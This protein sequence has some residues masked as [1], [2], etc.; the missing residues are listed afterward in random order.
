VVSTRVSPAERAPVGLPPFG[1][2]R[3]YFSNEL[4]NA[5][6]TLAGVVV[7]TRLVTPE[8]YG[9]YAV[10]I[11][12]ASV[13]MA[14]CG[15]WLQLSTLRLVAAQRR[16]SHRQTYVRGLLHLTLASTGALLAAAAA[17]LV[18]AGTPLVRALVVMGWLYATLNVLFLGTTIYFQATLQPARFARYRSAYSVLRVLFAALLAVLLAPSP[19]WLVAGSVLGLVVLLPPAIL[20]VLRAQARAPTAR[21]VAAARARVVRFGAP[22]IG[23]FAASQ[24]LN[25][26]DRFFLQGLLGSAEVGMYTVTYALVVG[27]T[28]T[29][30]QP[31]LAAVYPPMVSAWQQDGPAAAGHQLTGALRLFVLLAPLLLAGLTLYGDD[32]LAVLVPSAYQTPRLLVVVLA[33][34]LLCWN[35]GLYLQKG[36]ELSLKSTSLVKTLAAAAAANVVANLILI[37]RIGLLGAA[38]ATLIGYG[39]YA[40]SIFR[41]SRAA[42]PFALP[43]R[44]TAVAFVAAG[45]FV[46]VAVFLERGPAFHTG[47]ERILLAAPIATLAYLGVLYV[48]G[49]LR[50]AAVGLATTR[51]T[52]R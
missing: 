24:V 43:A 46:L 7:L 13:A 1:S 26:A 20:T 4:I 11:A 36:L 31:I 15:E 48:A 30:L 38:L 34:A 6:A 40:A 45:A 35:A 44:A 22:L 32:V 51:P 3:S 28:T 25:L 17:G 2:F 41:Q 9:A 16:E 18:L 8:V 5:L 50:L 21:R 39:I 27:A 47:W 23:W 19:V 10:T 29:L 52:A 49:E 37:D 33:G 14:L 12:A 42:L